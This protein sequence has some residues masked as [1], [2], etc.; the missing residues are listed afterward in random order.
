[1]MN[2][3]STHLLSLILFFPAFAAVLMLFMPKDESKLFR[4]YT[5]GASLVPFI[6]SLIAWFQFKP[7]QPGFQFEETYVWYQAIG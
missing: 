3:V 4:W 2:F 7:D 5:L 6:L 1:M